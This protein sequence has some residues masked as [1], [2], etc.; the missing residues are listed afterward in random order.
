MTKQKPEGTKDEERDLQQLLIRSLDGLRQSPME[1]DKF[2][3]LHRMLSRIE[4]RERRLAAD[5]ASWSTSLRWLAGPLTAAA[6]GFA[7]AALALVLL[8]GPKEEIS[9]EAISAALQQSLRQEAGENLEPS[10]RR[11]ENAVSGLEKFQPLLESR[12][13]WVEDAVQRNVKDAFVSVEHRKDTRRGPQP[14]ARLRSGKG[15]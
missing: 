8:P 1:R 14:A 6:A 2:P 4:A 12:I 11:L 15:V 9:T 7:G 3:A 5:D 13:E 10:I